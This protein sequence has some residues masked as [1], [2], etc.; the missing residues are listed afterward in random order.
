M[1]HKKCKV[2]NKNRKFLTDWTD[3]YCFTVPD[4]PEAISVCL[5]CNITSTLVKSANLKRHHETT[6]Q[7]FHMQE[8][9]RPQKPFSDSEAVKK[10]M[11]EVTVSLFEEK[12][13][14][15]AT[16]ERIP[17]SAGSSTMR[18]EILA[19]DNKSNVLETLHKG[20]IAKNIAI[21][22][23]DSWRR[24]IQGFGGFMTKSNL[25]FAKMVSLS[26]DGLQWRS[27]KKKEHAY[28]DQTVFSEKLTVTLKEVMANLMKL[29]TFMRFRSAL[30]QRQFKGIL[31]ECDSAHTNL[32][33]YNNLVG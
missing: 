29:I 26:C 17:L 20:R 19:A 14:V 2:D 10:C 31:S 22:R 1:D 12:T 27:A 5:T 30:Q 16:V 15:A 3:Q 32:V 24:F 4:R 8:S 9:S 11:L 25:S 33:Q 21:G 13:D 6:H 23:Q 18:A 7:Q 28:F